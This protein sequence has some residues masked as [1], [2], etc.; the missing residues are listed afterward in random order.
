M[1]AQAINLADILK[2]VPPGA[3]VAVWQYRVI[4]FGADMQQVLKD[5]RERGIPDPII[6]R[7][8]ERIETLF[9]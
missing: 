7:A 9:M 1:A 2:D 5:A 4:A 8:P 6:L 3:W